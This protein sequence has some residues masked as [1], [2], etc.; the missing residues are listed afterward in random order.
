ML[1]EGNE[2]VVSAWDIL[3]GDA[4][5]GRNVLIYDD[6][7]DYAA[8]QAAEK[9]AATGA[10]VEIMTRDRTFAP[11]VMAMSLTPSMRIL[12][13]HDVT[14][15][16]AWKLDAARR[17][18]NE[19]VARIGSDYGGFSRERRV[20]QIVVNHGTRPLDDVYFEMKPASRNG[21]AV[22]YEALVAGQPQAVVSN[23]EGTYELYRIGDA[24]SA[25]NTHAA[26]Y[27]ALRLVR[28]I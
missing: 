20:D 28:T 24:V 9:I 6:A 8:L 18:G 15:T 22:D 12:Q 25:R 11:E 13:E 23:L 26:I 7:G 14:F 21:G 3:S 10:R 16:V 19:L 2:L 17:D 5:P 27:D 4:Q 1:T